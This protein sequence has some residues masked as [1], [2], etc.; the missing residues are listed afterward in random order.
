MIVSNHGNFKESHIYVMIVDSITTQSGGKQ[1]IKYNELRTTLATL[2]SEAKPKF[3]KREYA[4][5][6]PVN[7]ICD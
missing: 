5:N 7:G 4:R 1:L 6:P 2:F 3:V